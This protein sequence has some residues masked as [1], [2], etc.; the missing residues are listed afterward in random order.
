MTPNLYTL[1]LFKIA[2]FASLS[3]IV[4]ISS[5]RII[6]RAKKGKISKPISYYLVTMLVVLWFLG[7]GWIITFG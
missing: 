6:G 1:I 3:A 7:L 2:L 4:G 5:W